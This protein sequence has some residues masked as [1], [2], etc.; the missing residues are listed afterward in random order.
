MKFG[1]FFQGEYIAM[2]GMGALVATFFLGGWHYPGYASVRDNLGVNV[3]AIISLV[4]FFAKVLGFI[5]FQIWVRWTLPRFRYDQLMTLGWKG[6][7]PFALA[8]MML[9]LLLNLK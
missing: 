9:T 1:M 4:S 8:N 6:L 2:V 5:L 7:I 3:A